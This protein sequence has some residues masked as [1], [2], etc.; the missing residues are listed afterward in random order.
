MSLLAIQV[1]DETLCLACAAER[2][3]TPQTDRDDVGHV[4]AWDVEPH[5]AVICLA[6]GHAAHWPRGLRLGE[7]TP[8]QR[9]AVTA[10][11]VRTVAAREGWRIA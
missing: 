5:A 11:A 2:G 10:R 9:R 7:L 4:M 8:A 1:A 3:V 6:C